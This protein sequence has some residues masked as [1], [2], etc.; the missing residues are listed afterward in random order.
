M[1]VGIHLGLTL[2]PCDLPRRGR[3]GLRAAAATCRV[4]K[5]YTPDS[6]RAP[7]GRVEYCGRQPRDWGRRHGARRYWWCTVRAISDANLPGIAA[8][9]SVRDFLNGSGDCGLGIRPGYILQMD[10]RLPSSCRAVLVVVLIGRACLVKLSNGWVGN[11]L[12]E[13]MA[14]CH[15]VKRDALVTSMVS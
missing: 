9:K 3:L 6:E 11:R 15:S 1:S 5:H 13:R 8:S 2:D 7:P 14:T 4:L 12:F 10:Q